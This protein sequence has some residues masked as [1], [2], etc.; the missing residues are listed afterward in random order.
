MTCSTSKYL[1]VIDYEH[2]TNDAATTII[3]GASCRVLQD[4]QII[5]EGEIPPL[6]QQPPRHDDEEPPGVNFFRTQL[7]DAALEHLTL[8]RTFFCRSEIRDVS[9]QDSA[10]L[11]EST[12]NWNPDFLSTSILAFVPIFLAATFVPPYSSACVSPEH[13]CVAQTFGVA[14]LRAAILPVRT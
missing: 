4:Q 8:P 14:V 3:R 9:F 10:D 6:P 11:S 2:F 7:A 1:D 12:A 5:D 13:P